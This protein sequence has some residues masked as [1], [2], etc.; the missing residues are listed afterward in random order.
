MFRHFKEGGYKDTMQG[1]VFSLD[2]FYLLRNKSL[3]LHY[4]RTYFYDLR[5]DFSNP[6]N[7]DYSFA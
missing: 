7:I 2:R 4:G 6:D 5:N 3:Y 1:F